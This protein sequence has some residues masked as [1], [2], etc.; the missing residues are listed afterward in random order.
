MKR[1]GLAVNQRI[2]YIVNGKREFISGSYLAFDHLDR[3]TEGEKLMFTLKAKTAFS[4]HQIG[5]TTIFTHCSGGLMKCACSSR[6]YKTVLVAKKT[7]FH[8]TCL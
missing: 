7:L 1:G 5:A 6:V 4:L 8:E 3:L 2:F